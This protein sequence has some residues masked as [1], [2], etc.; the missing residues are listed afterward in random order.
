MVVRHHAIFIG[1][2][3]AVLCLI[4]NVGTFGQANTFWA[5]ANPGRQPI[6]SYYFFAAWFNTRLSQLVTEQDVALA[7]GV[8]EL[9]VIGGAARLWRQRRSIND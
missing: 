4:A 2:T 9:I 8:V 7:A 3:F 6:T 1:V 5:I